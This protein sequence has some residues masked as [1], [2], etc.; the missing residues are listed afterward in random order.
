M[1]CIG[2]ICFVQPD[3]IMKI[4]NNPKN[5]SCLLTQL[6]QFSEIIGENRWLLWE[7]SL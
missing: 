6:R 2:I 3:S 4:S 5:G 7:Q 1:A